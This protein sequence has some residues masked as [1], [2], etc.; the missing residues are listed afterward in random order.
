MSWPRC[1]RMPALA[2]HGIP[3]VRS[4]GSTIVAK[5][6]QNAALMQAVDDL[7]P[8]LDPL[9]G[10]RRPAG[11]NQVVAVWLFPKATSMALHCR[12]RGA[13]RIAVGCVVAFS[14]RCCQPESLKDESSYA[15]GAAG[16][17]VD[18]GLMSSHRSPCPKPQ[19]RCKKRLGRMSLPNHEGY[20]PRI[21]PDGLK[22]GACLYCAT[23]LGL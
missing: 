11:P 6:K 17:M 20:R 22:R 9:D 15:S 13:V 19:R 5:R 12:N 16:C 8:F 18:A 10:G 21:A 4:R 14:G 1:A 3:V 2:R 7:K 23:N